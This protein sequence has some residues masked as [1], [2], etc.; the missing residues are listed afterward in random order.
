MSNGLPRGTGRNDGLADRQDARKGGQDDGVNEMDS[1]A[2]RMDG[3]MD[4]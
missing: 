1:Q 2:V 4:R 3:R